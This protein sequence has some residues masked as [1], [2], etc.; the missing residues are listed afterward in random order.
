MDKHQLTEIIIDVYKTLTPKKT[1]VFIKND[2]VINVRVVSD[3]FQG[4]TFSSRFKQ[5]NDMLKS[6]EPDLFNRFLFVFEAFTSAEMLKIPKDLQA[7][8][9]PISSA[10][11]SSAK[12][13][14]S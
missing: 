4:M 6:C 2:D 12:P 11:K 1:S 9:E 10:L 14:E 7:T 8:L 13:L 3:S 5:L